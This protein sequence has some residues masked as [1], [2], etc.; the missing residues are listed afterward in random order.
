MYSFS[1]YI[2][3]LFQN[4]YNNI[5]TMNDNLV[6]YELV[7]NPSNIDITMAHTSLDLM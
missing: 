1:I 5:P 4:I 3:K 7:E 2:K 6:D